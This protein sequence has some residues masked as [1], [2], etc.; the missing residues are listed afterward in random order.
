MVPAAAPAAPSTTTN[1][2]D[3]VGVRYITMWVDDVATVV[4]RWRARAGQVLL[5]PIELRPGVV[6]ALLADPDG[7]R[8]EVMQG[9]G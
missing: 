9:E 3:Q 2:W 4:E 8:V 1:F 5:E 6:M 7:N